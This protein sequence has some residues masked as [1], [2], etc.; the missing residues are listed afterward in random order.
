MHSNA[1]PFSKSL[2]TFVIFCLISLSAAA[3]ATIKTIHLGVLVE[4]NPEKSTLFIQGLKI[5]LL[6]LLSTKYNIQLQASL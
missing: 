2:L 1:K 3:I 4:E 6:A 5:E